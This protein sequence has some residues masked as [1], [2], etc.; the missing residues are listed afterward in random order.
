MSR[1]TQLIKTQGLGL[2]AVL[3]VLTGGAAYAGGL[4][5]NSVN[6]SH[7]KNGKVK[8]VDL[9]DEA[10]TGDKIEPGSVPGDRLIHH[11]VEGAKITSNAITSDKVLDESLTGFEI[12]PDSL[13]AHDLAP[14]SVGS[15]ELKTLHV[16]VSAGVAVPAGGSLL[17]V[18]QCPANELVT[19]GGHAWGTDAA[20]TSI[21]GSTPNLGGTRWEVTGRAAAANTLYAWALCLPV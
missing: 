15:S 7:I 5:K 2:L 4:A 21:I 19:G 13:F 18:A 17:D 1:I 8:T 10:V 20:G 16:V 9:K 3:L 11:S 12:A 14:D 6:S